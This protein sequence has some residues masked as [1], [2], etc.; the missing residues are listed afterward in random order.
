[1]AK[2][3]KVI[4]ASFVVLLLGYI[5]SGLVFFYGAYALSFLPIFNDTEP[6]QQEI[7]T[8]YTDKKIYF[9]GSRDGREYIEFYYPND[10]DDSEFDNSEYFKKVSEEDIET[11]TEYVDLFE[12][13]I[14]VTFDDFLLGDDIKKVYSFNKSLIDTN[15]YFYT[16]NKDNFRVYALFYYDSDCKTAFKLMAVK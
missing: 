11:I 8:D 4:L 14:E 15:D 6:S 16:I 3:I 13:D 10:F 1:M 2:A 5:S 7:V 12:S 9:F